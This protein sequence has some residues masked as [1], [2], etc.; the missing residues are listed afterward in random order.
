MVPAGNLREGVPD[1]P[2]RIRVFVCGIT[3]LPQHHL[4]ERV[5]EYFGCF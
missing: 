4:L 1:P 5:L 2:P 3:A